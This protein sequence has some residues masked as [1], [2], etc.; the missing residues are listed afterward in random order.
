[1]EESLKNEARQKMDAL[2]NGSYKPRGSTEQMLS[3]LEDMGSKGVDVKEL[4]NSQDLRRLAYGKMTSKLYGF[5]EVRDNKVYDEQG[6]F[7]LTTG[8]EKPELKVINSDCAE[9]PG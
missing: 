3:F 6:K 5:Q 1:M 2:E 7:F 9:A 8:A 4:V